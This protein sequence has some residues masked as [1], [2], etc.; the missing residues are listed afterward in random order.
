MRITL[1]NI[2]RAGVQLALLLG[3]GCA[4]PVGAFVAPTGSTPATAHVRSGHRPATVI[5]SGF[6]S[7]R[8]GYALPT[9]GVVPGLPNLGSDELRQLFGDGVCAGFQG[10]VCVLS[11]A[12]AWMAQ[13]NAQM[14][15]GH[16][17]GLSSRHCSSLPS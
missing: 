11:P 4:L 12:L 1:R 7:K 5:A 15:D 14:A 16:C 8:D 6:T 9:S 2:R 3:A 13:E 10:G 17:E